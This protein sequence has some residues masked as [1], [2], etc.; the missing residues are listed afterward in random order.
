MMS[1]VSYSLP[2]IIIAP[3][4]SADPTILDACIDAMIWTIIEPGLSIA[5]A[6]IATFRPLLQVFKIRGFTSDGP[7]HRGP[8]NAPRESTGIVRPQ[9]LNKILA[10]TTITTVI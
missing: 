8:G 10:T 9:D 4:K 1:Y 7:A 2:S 3:D 6:S 5:A